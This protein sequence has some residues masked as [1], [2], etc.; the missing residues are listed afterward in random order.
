M[1]ERDHEENLKSLKQICKDRHF[2]LNDDKDVIK[3]DRVT[4]MGHSITGD[5]IKADDAKATAILEMPAPTDIH[6]VKRFCGMIQYLARFMP[7]LAGYLEPLRKLTR[8]KAKWDWSPEC[9][10]AF[11]GVKKMISD[12]TNSGVFRPRKRARTS[13]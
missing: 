6:G 3:Q 9:M 13:S 8:Q 4:F 11:N 2:N 5:G 1:A 12:N 10:E 7:D